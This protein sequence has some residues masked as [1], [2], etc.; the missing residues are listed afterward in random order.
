MENIETMQEKWEELSVA[1]ISSLE[2][3][4]RIRSYARNYCSGFY[5]I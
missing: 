5:R 3:L 2:R 1:T 4:C